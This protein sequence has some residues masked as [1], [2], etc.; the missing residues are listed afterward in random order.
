MGKSFDG[1]KVVGVGVFGNMERYIDM[2]GIDNCISQFHCASLSRITVESICQLRS[3]DF[4]YPHA[5]RQ[6]LTELAR[7]LE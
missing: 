4:A 6:C 3:G 7:P 1:L 5:S 2:E